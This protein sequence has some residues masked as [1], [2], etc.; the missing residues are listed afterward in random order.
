VEDEVVRN[1]KKMFPKM[2]KE[3][4]DLQLPGGTKSAEAVTMT[5]GA[6]FQKLPKE[7]IEVFANP[8]VVAP[9]KIPRTLPQAALIN[10]LLAESMTVQSSGFFKRTEFA[11]CIMSGESLTISG[12]I[13]I[14]LK[15]LGIRSNLNVGILKMKREEDGYLPLV[16]LTIHGTLIDN[17]YH[18]WPRN[19]AEVFDKEMTRAKRMEFYSEQDPT[20]PSLKLADCLGSTTCPQDPKLYKAFGNV[21]DIEKYIVF[22]ACTPEVYP[23]MRLFSMGIAGVLSDLKYPVRSLPEKWEK[24]CWNC[25]RKSATLKSCTQCKEGMGMYCNTECQKADWESHKLL[26]KDLRAN[27]RYWKAK[28][29]AGRN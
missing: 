4:Q 18:Y 20:D 16:W 10:T 14:Y 22:R 1:S 27:I 24:L 29:A 13:H 6:F 12:L 7:R 5:L 17:T 11:K 2:F 26:H 8:E 28:A 15:N 21:K 9:W 19:K 23:N 25:E 3:A